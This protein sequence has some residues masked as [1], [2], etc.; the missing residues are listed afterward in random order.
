[1]K[2][3]NLQGRAYPLKVST[4]LNEKVSED[5][6][7]DFEILENSYTYD[8]VGSITKMWTVSEVAGVNDKRVYRI[9]ILDKSPVG[10]KLKISI[11]ARER[12]ID[13]LQNKRIYETFTGSF[14]GTKYFDL[15]FKD[16]NYKYKFTHKVNAKKFENVGDGESKLDIMKKGLESFGL[17]YAYDEPSKTF[18]FTPSVQNKPKYFFDS[19][20]NANNVKIEEDATKCYTYIKGYGDYTGEQTHLEGGLQ[21]EYE[22][23]LASVIGRREAPP[24]KN[25]NIT[26]LETMK[27][28][29]EA[30]IDKSM[31][32]S[33]SVDFVTLPQSFKEAVP[34]IGDVV[35]LRDDITSIDNEDVRIV[36][37]TTKRDPYGKVVK[38]DVVIGDFRLRERYNRRVHNAANFVGN[39]GG[40]GGLGG[41]GGAVN[42]NTN[43]RNL[44]AQV[45]ATSN[46]TTKLIDSSQALD[47]DIQG[48]T[49][50][51]DNGAV[52][53][54]N[55][56]VVYSKDNTNFDVAIDG[57]G[58]NPKAIPIATK[59]A[60][61]AMSKEDKV[62]LDNFTGNSFVLTDESN[63][64]TKYKVSINN[65]QFKI[66]EVK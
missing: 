9:V 8:I 31:N 13:D 54:R 20:I 35:K 11:K 4:T 14:T 52:A 18:T 26:K 61:G 2:L 48:I 62:K 44:S 56:G 3:F 59:T 7:L 36:E 49:G 33:I 10:E 32:V 5:G 41:L 51:G 30:E 64:D 45:K 12:E 22:H 46:V 28:Y 38:Q 16:T 58:I 1:M 6:T 47:Y 23:P 37:I 29:L 60:N 66:Q 65:G 24:I 25:G 50:K 42:F 21:V 43:M 17:E 34:R 40:I 57:K 27:A 55:S 19:K 63:P 15:V 53:L 39:L